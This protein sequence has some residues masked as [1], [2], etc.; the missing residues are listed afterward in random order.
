MKDAVLHSHSLVGYYEIGDCF[1]YILELSS[2][3]F[4]SC[5]YF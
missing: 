4:C 3:Y 2:I 1:E 5:Y